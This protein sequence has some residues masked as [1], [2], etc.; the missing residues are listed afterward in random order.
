MDIYMY[1][2][3]AHIIT[4]K[5]LV[6]S[7][8]IRNSIW[9]YILQLFN[10]VVPLITL[11]YI[12]RI[13][14]KGN[15][16][17][18]SFSLNIIEYLIV[19]VEYGFNYSGTRKIALTNS[20]NEIRE[21]FVIILICKIILMLFCF[22]GLSILL[23]FYPLNSN[24]K[25]SCY[26]LFLSVFG[27]AFQQTWL[28]Q[29]LQKVYYITIISIIS[30]TISLC[31]I[32]RYVLSPDDVLIYCLL[33]SITPLLIGIAGIIFAIRLLGCP[34]SLKV[35][36]SNIT[37]EI[38]SGWYTFTTSLSSKIFSAVGVTILGI[39]S[40][41]ENVGIYSA[42]HKVP[43]ILLLLW[44]PISQVLYPLSSKKMKNNIWDG[45]Q[46][47][48]RI[49]KS[50]GLFFSIVS[51]I[52]CIFSKHIITIAFGSEYESY[53][54]ILIPLIIWLNIGIWN[55]FLGVQTL[56]AGGYDQIYSKCFQISVVV[57]IISNVILIGLFDIV[58][59]A[60][61]PLLSESVLFILLASE[62]KK[63]F[64]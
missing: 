12:T 37:N 47:I 54:Y 24:Q 21:I 44:T 7:K 58:G 43:S 39:I 8:E 2:V 57:T 18:F 50:I 62:V 1:N 4:I 60:M 36:F 20:K 45:Q 14:G 11:P 10:S 3:N 27:T 38:K 56:L 26:I 42:I 30:R 19:I 32:F 5:M 31:L 35:T 34:I 13:L 64:N 46:F 28:F 48:R 33:Y 61:A 16:G 29:G 40:S 15:F 25:I 9:L 22:G 17:V 51:I 52:I 63:I 23:F 59:A 49:S 53:F 6:K 41:N 55:N